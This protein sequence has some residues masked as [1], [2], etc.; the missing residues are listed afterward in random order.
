MIL[1]ACIACVKNIKLFWYVE[2]NL[3]EIYQYL[4]V[5]YTGGK[6]LL[7]KYDQFIKSKSDTE[8]FNSVYPLKL[9]YIVWKR[10]Q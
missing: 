7:C 5:N 3:R 2:Q 1:I 9:Q 6:L 10:D 4:S 8:L